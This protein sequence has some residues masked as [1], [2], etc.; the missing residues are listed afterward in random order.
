MAQLAQQSHNEANRQLT[1]AA[2][3][4]TWLYVSELAKQLTVIEP[5]GPTLSVDGKNP[6]PAMKL[7]AFQSDA[8]KKK[9]QDQEVF[10]YITMGWRIVPRDGAP[11]D[12]SVSVNFLPEMQRIEERLFAGMIKHNRI[13]VKHPEK[14]TLQ[15]IQ[16]DYVTE[17]RGSL[18]I[19]VNHA[20]AQL[21]FRLV[22]VQGFEVFKT[23]Y[24][25]D[26]VEGPLLD[27]LAKLLVGEASSFIH[28][29]R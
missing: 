28:G 6:W 26:K 12:C 21:A 1:E 4:T 20:D 7:T 14:K 8:R 2:A 19:Q 23:A 24:A 27:E 5:N 16:F 9:L 25:A 15:A 10:D 13:E 18:T 11:L 29:Y 22:N 3:Q 17:A